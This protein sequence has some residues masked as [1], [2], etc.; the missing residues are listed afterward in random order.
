MPDRRRQGKARRTTRP[1]PNKRVY[2][3]P[4]RR[5][6]AGTFL[7]SLLRK[8]IDPSRSRVLEI[9]IGDGIFGN[10]LGP[11]TREYHGIDPVMDRVKT[12]RV[13][14]VGF[15]PHYVVGKGEQLPFNRK[16][17]AVLCTRSW[18]F[19]E[20]ANAIQEIARVLDKNGVLIIL[21][22]TEFTQKWKDDSLNRDSPHFSPEGY[23]RKLADLKRG[24]KFIESQRIFDIMEARTIN[25]KALRIWVLK[26]AR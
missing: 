20:H 13:N 7:L 2:Q 21:E 18:H 14:A 3:S 22:P 24:K 15:N 26:K 25:Y 17:Q 19:L 6:S 16:Y 9:G 11:H 10:A 1:R 5:K 8:Y 4:L 12:A 23:A